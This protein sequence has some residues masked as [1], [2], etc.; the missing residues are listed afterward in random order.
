MSTVDRL[1]R[2]LSDILDNDSLSTNVSHTK[3]PSLTFAE[4]DYHPSSL[5]PS[6]TGRVH[7][8]NSASFQQS[9]Y[10]SSKD[11]QSI[12]SPPL[13]NS[14]TLDDLFRALTLECEQYLA[15][16]ASS[17][18]NRMQSSMTMPSS[19]TSSLNIRTALD[20]NDDDYENLTQLISSPSTTGVPLLKTS[21]EVTSPEKK[22]IVSSRISSSALV[23][24]TSRTFPL[25]SAVDS[26]STTRTM[27]SVATPSI[28]PFHRCHSTD[29]DNNLADSLN[30]VRRRRR[31]CTRKQAHVAA[32]KQSNSSSSDEHTEKCQRLH[33]ER[34]SHVFKR[35]ASS[36][37]DYRHNRLQFCHENSI[38]VASSSPSSSSSSSSSSSPSSSSS[39]GSSISAAVATVAQ[40][41]SVKYL[42]RRD[43]SLQ[44]V[45]VPTMTHP[46]SANHSR[47]FPVDLYSPLSVLLTSTRVNSDFLDRSNQQRR[48]RL[49]VVNQRALPLLDHMHRPASIPS[50]NKQTTNIPTHGMP[51]YSVY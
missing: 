18:R 40:Q 34:K 32:N 37:A 8:R 22:R 33:M 10:S 35:S 26:F 46:N 30:T 50:T 11:K 3:V 17:D 25:L 42:R 9:I 44:H 24:P 7:R 19:S 49:K 38:V 45:Q 23:V 2:L 43:I 15:A 36:A 39:S 20:S 5:L 31:R 51:S 14:S 41:A 4:H 16:S 28:I 29:D 47:R 21:I 6:T 13:L 1:N 48:S 27:T 12:V